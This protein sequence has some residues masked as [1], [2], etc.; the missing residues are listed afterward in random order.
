MNIECIHKVKISITFAL[1]M[2]VSVLSAS[3]S[4]PVGLEEVEQPPLPGEQ[5]INLDNSGHKLS[6]FTNRPTGNKY[7]FYNKYIWYIQ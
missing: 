5:G 6:D 3:E 1:V 4:R 2:H 7:I